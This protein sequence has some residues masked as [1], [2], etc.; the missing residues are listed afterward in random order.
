MNNINSFLEKFSRSSAKVQFHPEITQISWDFPTFFKLGWLEWIP[1]GPL[2]TLEMM[3]ENPGGNE[4]Q[5]AT[6]TELGPQLE[7]WDFYI[8]KVSMLNISRYLPKIFWHSVSKISKA[9]NKK[10]I[11]MVGIPPIKMVNVGMVYHCITPILFPIVCQD[12]VVVPSPYSPS[13]PPAWSRVG[14]LTHMF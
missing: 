14:D 6:A 10:H 13:F 4:K 9:I 12:H 7:S 2:N 1:N 3:L 11:L 5:L 8:I